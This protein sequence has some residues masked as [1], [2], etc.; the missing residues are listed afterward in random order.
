MKPLFI[1]IIACISLSSCVKENKYNA[2]VSENKKLKD[3]ITALQSE[4]N[5][6]DVKIA[7]L[8]AQ[9]DAL[10]DK[11]AQYNKTVV[12]PT[13]ELQTLSRRAIYRDLEP[14]YII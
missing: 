8:G 3:Q 2:A 1:I 14:S 5:Q 4:V 10:R 11:F 13:N 12:L 7:E 6:K 9:L